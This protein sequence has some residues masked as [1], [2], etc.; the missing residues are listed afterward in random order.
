MESTRVRW[1]GNAVRIGEKRNACTLLVG[2]RD[3]KSSLGKL[4]RRWE[5]YNRTNLKEIGWDDVDWVYIAQDRRKWRSHVNTVINRRIPSNAI[6]IFTR[7]GTVSFFKN[8][9]A[10]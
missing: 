1:A 2:K 10:P 6:S 9:P 5:C 4:R 3:R 7:R 8:A